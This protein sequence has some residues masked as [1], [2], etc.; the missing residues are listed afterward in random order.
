MKNRSVHTSAVVFATLAMMLILTLIL[1]SSASAQTEKVL[2]NFNANSTKDGANPYLY[3]A[4]V[5][6][7]AGNLYGTAANGGKTHGIAFKLTPTTK[8]QWKEQVMHNFAGYD[9]ADPSKSDGDFPYAA[10]IE[11]AS[12]NFYGVADEGGTLN[13]GNVY[14]LSPTASGGWK[15]TILYN[16]TNGNDGG[17]PG[18]PLVMDSSGNL[19]GV[20]EGGNG[21]NCDNGCGV[22]FELS[23]TTKGPWKETTVHIFQGTAPGT[24]PPQPGDVD[25]GSDPVG[26]LYIDSSGNMFGATALG[27]CNNEDA[28]NSG[29]VYELTPNGS[30]GWNYGQILA[31]PSPNGGSNPSGSVVEDSSGN[32]YGMYSAGEGGV[33]TCLASACSSTYY[34]V[35]AF[36]CP[37]AGCGGLPASTRGGGLILDSLGNL[38]GTSYNG[39]NVYGTVFELSPGQTWTE[40]TLWSFTET[41]GANPYCTLIRDS[42]G[43]FYGSTAYGGVSSGTGSGVIFEVTP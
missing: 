31:L 28:I 25:D 8:G 9:T 13:Y 7:S 39:G 36:S 41:D 16:F 5:M 27:G 20:A 1:A 34:L 33:W 3:G 21:A 22:L 4:L 11:D 43:N 14:K 26:P 29:T 38:Y 17:Y 18:Y 2:F 30:G 42:E 40:E 6:D 19:Y 12:G 37:P 15:E 10:L 32:L 23:P 24:C 35:D